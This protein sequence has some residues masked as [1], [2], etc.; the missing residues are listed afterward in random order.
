MNRLLFLFLA[1]SIWGS[2]TFAPSYAS[3]I[4]IQRI[5]DPVQDTL[6]ENG[7]WD[8]TL[9]FPSVKALLQA[10]ARKQKQLRD[11]YGKHKEEKDAQFLY[12]SLQYS[13]TDNFAVLM[14]K[15]LLRGEKN[16]ASI[17]AFA[18]AARI[19][20][21][22]GKARMEHLLSLY[23]PA[24]RKNPNGQKIAGILRG[25]SANEGKNIRRLLEATVIRSESGSTQKLA[26]LIRESRVK[27]LVFGGSWCKPCRFNDIEIH[28]AAENWVSSGIQIYHFSLDR[29]P[30][31]WK[32]N[33]S[34]QSLGAVS[35][36]VEGNFNSPLAKQL[37]FTGVPQY[38]VVDKNGDVLIDV[39]N[40]RQLIERIEQIRKARDI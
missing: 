16:A 13:S 20:P 37:N 38:I 6:P 5:S 25:I 14:Y 31:K 40:A 19:S 30:D 24:L 23:P 11:W 32:A 27:V 8:T 36:L 33:K 34:L 21:Y 7:A 15:H 2:I 17:G 26:A 22:P 35:W 29:D 9:V 18:F 3:F 4:S 10:D 12:D 28:H 39:Y 1:I